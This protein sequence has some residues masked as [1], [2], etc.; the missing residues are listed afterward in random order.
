MICLSLQTQNREYWNKFIMK[1]STD[2]K[3][4]LNG[5]LNYE[6]VKFYHYSVIA[7]VRSVS[8]ELNTYFLTR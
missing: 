6:K 1:N 7:T 5:S 2:G 8:L 3:I 4:Y